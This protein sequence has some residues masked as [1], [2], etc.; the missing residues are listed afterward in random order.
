M[1]VHPREDS[2]RVGQT[3]RSV[4]ELPLAVGM[5]ARDL[6]VRES[7]DD[8]EWPAV[9]VHPVCEGPGRRGAFVVQALRGADGG[10]RVR[11]RVKKL[12]ELAIRL[13]KPELG[14]RFEPRS[15]GFASAPDAVEAN[16]NRR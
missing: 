16:T 12:P 10:V 4:T 15:S 14:R 2:S 13:G 9:V 7:Q 6:Q 5:T 8:P 3:A 1:L 11:L